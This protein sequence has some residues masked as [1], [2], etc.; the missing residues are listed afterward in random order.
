LLCHG[1]IFVQSNFYMK[2]LIDLEQEKEKLLQ[3]LEQ[4]KKQIQQDISILEKKYTPQNIKKKVTREISKQYLNKRNLLILG[5][6]A[7]AL[8][9]FYLLS[10]NKKRNK[11]TVINKKEKKYSDYKKPVLKSNK[12]SFVSELAKEIIWTVALEVIRKKVNEYIKK[13]SAT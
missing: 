11:T 9:L 4:L 2:N 7:G 6:S 12:S 13:K 5:T 10:R 3:E 1:L 8:I